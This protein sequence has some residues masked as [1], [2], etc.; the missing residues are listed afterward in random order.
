MFLNKHEV[1]NNYIIRA[2]LFEELPS[3]SILLWPDFIYP[4]GE[5]ANTVY[6]LISKLENYLKNIALAG[7]Y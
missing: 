1:C 3:L 2:N 4:A 7:H 5:Q 6:F